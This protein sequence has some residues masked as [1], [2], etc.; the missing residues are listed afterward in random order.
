MDQ[1]VESYLQTLKSWMRGHINW[2]MFDTKRF[3]EKKGEH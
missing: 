1:Q 2:I 3:E